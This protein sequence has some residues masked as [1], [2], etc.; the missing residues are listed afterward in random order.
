MATRRKSAYDDPVVDEIHKIRA[1][2]WRQGGGTVAGYIQ[3]IN[4][5]QA[6]RA[7]QAKVNGPVPKGSTTTKSG[8]PSRKTRPRK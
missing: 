1:K 6:A 8:R 7:E 4:A 3:M 5:R 2:L